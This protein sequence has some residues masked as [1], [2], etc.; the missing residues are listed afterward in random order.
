MHADAIKQDACDTAQHH[1]ASLVVQGLQRCPQDCLLL[2]QRLVTSVP[3]ELLSSP[4]NVAIRPHQDELH[5]SLNLQHKG[6]S[7]AQRFHCWCSHILSRVPLRPCPVVT[8]QAEQQGAGGHLSQ[9]L[10]AASS[11]LLLLQQLGSWAGAACTSSPGVVCVKDLRSLDDPGGSL[12]S[13]LCS[14]CPRG[15]SSAPPNEEEQ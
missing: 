4:G 9:G 2:L 6:R 12:S 5:L 14:S 7:V 15:C 13:L 11:H 3:S 10:P 8:M 1:S